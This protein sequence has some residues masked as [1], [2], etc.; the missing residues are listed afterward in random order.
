MKLLGKYLSLVSWVI[1]CEFSGVRIEAELPS[2][3]VSFVMV[4]ATQR[5]HVIKIC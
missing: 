4:L 1:H 3:L 2:A 5:N